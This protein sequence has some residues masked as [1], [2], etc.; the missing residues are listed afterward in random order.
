MDDPAVDPRELAGNF[1]D[2]ERANRLFGGIAPVVS[3]V[4]SRKTEW[5][6]DVGC[7]SGDIARALIREAR[8]RGRRLEIVGVDHSETVLD[9]A[10]ER[11]RTD[12][13]I[14]F[15]Y[16]D[17]T[18]LPFPDHSFD[19]ATCNLTLHHFGPDEAVHAL[20]ELRRVS[21]MT[22][23]VC[24]LRRSIGSYLATVL[25]VTLFAKNR[26]TKHD[27]PLSARRAYTPREA[28]GLA[29]EAGWNAPRVVRLPW[30]RMLLYDDGG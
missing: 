15:T 13:Q 5:V 6:L 26:L 14:R 29:R 21:R 10:R 2:I 22:P 30:E 3:E 23:L 8:R 25:Y 24:D 19:I 18:A 28:L 16:A 20:R 9:I 4:F 11:T 17:A 27:G 1:D 12:H 7:G